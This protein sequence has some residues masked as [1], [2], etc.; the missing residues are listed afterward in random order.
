MPQNLGDS[1]K[2]AFRV[3]DILELLAERPVALSHAQIGAALDIPKSS[4]TGLLRTMVAR[5]YAEAED[6][7]YRLG[8]RVAALVAE[9]S[10]RHGAADAARPIIARL[11][12]EVGESAGFSVP[13]GDGSRLIAATNARHP[14]VFVFSVGTI[15]PLFATSSGKAILAHLPED[16]LAAYLARE[17]WQPLTPHTVRDAATLRAQL[18]QARRDGIA[19]SHEER[20]PGIVGIAAAVLDEKRRPLG[21]VNVAMPTARFGAA[22]RIQVPEAVRQAAATLAR[23]LCPD[24]AGRPVRKKAISTA[25]SSAGRSSGT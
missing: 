9:A 10:L 21:A 17:S 19:Y 7:G 6:G 25:E 14:L 3:L 16:D 24:H 15:L 11:S 20:H 18:A 12:A 23:R 2:S 13:E 22:A 5:G 1:V 8:P 4:L